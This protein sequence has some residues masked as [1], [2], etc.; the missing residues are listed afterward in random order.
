VGE[1]RYI[2]KNSKN[3]RAGG[4]GKRKKKK[5]KKKKNGFF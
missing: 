5:K 3:V 2:K 4:A 1:E